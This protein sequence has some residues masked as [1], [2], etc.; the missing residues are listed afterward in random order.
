MSIRVNEAFSMQHLII[1]ILFRV[2]L[3]NEFLQGKSEN[4]YG[5]F[6][7]IMLLIK[8]D[9]LKQRQELLKDV[10]VSTFQ[11]QLKINILIR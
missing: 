7:Y 11:T 10:L 8:R 4:E 5:C 3:F 2:V 1:I 6:T 9:L